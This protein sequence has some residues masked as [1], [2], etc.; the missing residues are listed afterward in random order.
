[1]RLRAQRRGR[2]PV[3]G[4]ICAGAFLTFAT[5]TNA[6]VP[7]AEVDLGP[8]CASI[9]RERAFR[10]PAR[11]QQRRI[12]GMAMLDCT[13]S[14]GGALAS[15]APIIETPSGSRFGDAAL[16][17]ACFLQLEQDAATGGYASDQAKGVEIYLDQSGVER[18][19]V[20]FEFRLE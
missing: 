2:L 7:P 4:A 9:S 12:Q 15:C 1:M 8:I 6:Y 20:T 13:I 19:R 17:M 14:S 11:A 5:Q 3:L 18:A 10:Y 16:G